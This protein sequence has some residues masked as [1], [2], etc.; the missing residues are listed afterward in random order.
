MISRGGAPIARLVPVTAAPAPGT[1][2]PVPTRPRQFGLYAGWATLG[3]GFFEPLPEEELSLK[4]YGFSRAILDRRW[5]QGRRDAER[6]IALR[7]AE[8]PSG[9]GLRV[10]PP[11]RATAAAGTP[12]DPA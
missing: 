4:S 3:P 2:H 9:R 5:A 12:R 8:P 10:H 1:E 7:R 6:A 11:I